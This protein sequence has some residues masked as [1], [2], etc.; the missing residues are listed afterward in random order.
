MKF[1]RDHHP[2]QVPNAGGVGKIAFFFDRSS[3]LRLR[4]L[5]AE[6]LCPSS[7]VVHVQDG[8]LQLGGI[9]GVTNSVGRG[10]ST[11]I[12]RTAHSELHV[13]DTAHRMIA[14]R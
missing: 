13:C 11:L 1:P 7:A 8:A 10:G 14:V 3:S 9:R 4:G 5:T 2:Q 12:T 6:N